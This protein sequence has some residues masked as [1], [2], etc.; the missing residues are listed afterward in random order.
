MQL[1]VIA[2]GTFTWV[3]VLKCKCSTKALLLGLGMGGGGS[4]QALQLGRELIHE[5]DT[6]F[7]Y[8]EFSNIFFFEG[9]FD[10]L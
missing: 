8:P 4:L 1:L 10:V 5:P 7:S 2:P 9:S 6:F 3:L